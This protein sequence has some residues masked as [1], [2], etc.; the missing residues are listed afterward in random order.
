MIAMRIDFNFPSAILIISIYIKISYLKSSCAADSWK[1]TYTLFSHWH[2]YDD[3]MESHGM[4]EIRTHFACYHQKQGWDRERVRANDMGS[5]RERE[6]ERE[7][8]YDWGDTAPRQPIEPITTRNAM[9][10]FMS[11][12]CQACFI[13]CLTYHLPYILY[14]LDI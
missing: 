13:E 4:R 6:K 8:G 14:I 3:S 10:R 5:R 12:S 7:K 9:E 2:W 1:Y 11:F